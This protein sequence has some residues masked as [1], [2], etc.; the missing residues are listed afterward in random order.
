MS[1]IVPVTM[2][3]SATPSRIPADPPPAM[4]AGYCDG[5]YAWTPEDWARFPGAEKLITTTAGSM[6]AN[7]A[8]VERFDMTP[9][10]GAEWIHAKQAAAAQEGKPAAATIYCSLASELAVR[11]TCHGLS[12]YL[13]I[14][15]WIDTTTPPAAPPPIPGTVGQQ[16]WN[17]PDQAYDLSVIYNRGWLDRINFVNRPWPL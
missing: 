9:A 2:F 14:A 15:S 5:I 6:R 4:V 12:Y 11:R 8:D 16:Y 1:R 7:M 10:D 17:S 3:D 13:L